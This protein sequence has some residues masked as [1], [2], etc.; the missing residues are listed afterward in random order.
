MIEKKSTLH[1]EIITEGEGSV[2]KKDHNVTI[3]YTGTLLDGTKFDSS[4]ERETPLTFTYGA[5]DVIAGLEKGMEGM[6]VGEI[7]RI[8]IP[9]DLAYGATGAGGVIPPNASLIFEV[10]LLEVVDKENE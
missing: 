7:R 2:V 6:K 10:E 5:G 9:P 3:H 4:I 1:T 8:H